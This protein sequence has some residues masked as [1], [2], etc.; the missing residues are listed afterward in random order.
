[1]DFQWSGHTVATVL[2]KDQQFW[3]EKLEKCVEDIPSQSCDCLV[4]F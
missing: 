4:I 3:S 1:M 2:A